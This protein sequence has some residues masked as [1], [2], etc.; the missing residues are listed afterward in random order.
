MEIVRGVHISQGDA[1]GGPIVPRIFGVGVPNPIGYIA[2]GFKIRGFQ[3]SCD[4]NWTTSSFIF[5]VCSGAWCSVLLLL[6]V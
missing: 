6:V 5:I 1:I 4:T 3:I 2:W